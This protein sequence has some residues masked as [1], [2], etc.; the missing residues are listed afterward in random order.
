MP[1]LSTKLLLIILGSRSGVLSYIFSVLSR[2]IKVP[3]VLLLLASGIILRFI[4]NAE[5]W[6]IALPPQIR[7]TAGRYRSYHDRTRSG[8]DLRLGKEKKSEPYPQFFS[9]LLYCCS[10]RPVL[11]W[12][13]ITGCTS[14]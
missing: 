14:R 3:S 10:P 13:C 11:A 6:N 4:A 12:R 8:A 1:A 9:A 7:R 5:H 2:Y